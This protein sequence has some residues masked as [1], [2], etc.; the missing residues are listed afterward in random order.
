MSCEP[1]WA[2]KQ[3]I[4]VTRFL[5]AFHV[6]RMLR[7]VC[8]LLLSLPDGRKPARPTAPLPTRRRPAVKHPEIK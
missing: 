7:P 2:W 8:L 4:A 5:L 1:N 3:R 6:R